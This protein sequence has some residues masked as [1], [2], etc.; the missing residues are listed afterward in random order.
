MNKVIV[1]EHEFLIHLISAT[2]SVVN[3]L[4]KAIVNIFLFNSGGEIEVD[5]DY[6]DVIN[7][8]FGSKIKIFLYVFEHIILCKQYDLNF[9]YYKVG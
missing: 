1:V 8:D 3:I 6:R 4:L 7:A 5:T 9:Y 2:K